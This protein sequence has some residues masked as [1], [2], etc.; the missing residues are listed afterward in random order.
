MR[1]LS[2]LKL[3]AISTPRVLLRPVRINDAK[4]MHEAMSNSFKVLHKWM[5]WAHSLAS[6]EDT[7][8]YLAHGERIWLDTPQDGKEMPM[9]I[10]DLEN[11]NYIGATGIKPA[12]LAIPTFEIGYWVNE[13]YKSQGL[14]T[15]AMNALTRYLLEGLG[16]KRVEINCEKDNIKSYQ[17]AERLNYVKEGTLRN[18]RFKAD[19]KTITDSL[20]YSCIDSS[21]LPDIK[22]DWRE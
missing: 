6:L 11:Q 18:Y 15:E 16:A 8:H 13:E 19:G 14:I 1:I 22:W 20:I 7:R 9:Q 21:T 10:M 4:I 17:V 5:P 12:N 3:D 2:P